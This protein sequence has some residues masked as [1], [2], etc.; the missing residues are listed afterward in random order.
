MELGVTRKGVVFSTPW[1]L[2]TNPH[3]DQV[4]ESAVVWMRKFGL[5]NGEQAAAEF[6]NWRLAEV[7]AFFYP[8]AS[9]EDCTTAAQMMGWYFLPFDDQLDG[10]VGRAPRRVAAICDALIGIVYGVSGPERY[11]APTVRAFAD[12]WPRMVDGMSGPL[13]SRTAYHWASYFSSQL[14]EATDRASGFAYCDLGEYFR[15]R[16]A[17]TCAFGQNDLGETW[18][19]DEVAPVVWH[20]P[21]LRRM[22]ELGADLVALRNDSMS[23]THED[24]AGGHNSIHI[25]ERTRACPRD[26]ALAHASGLAQG[27]VDELAELEETALPRLGRHLDDAQ[28]AAVRGYAE[29]IHDWVRGDY[30]WEQ[31]STRHDEHRTMPEWAAGLLVGGEG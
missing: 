7:A 14:T 13:R 1:P 20:H 31:I 19:G 26:D 15:L 8:S 22:R 23:L 2:R 24:V 21:V 9:A 6:T 10:A 28:R 27:M 4:R 25:I 5:L 18:G 29:I 11:D 30:E 17:T 16:A 3:L 12:L